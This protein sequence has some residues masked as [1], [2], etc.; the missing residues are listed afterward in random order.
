MKHY[1]N[2]NNNITVTVAS[3]FT[4]EE[5]YIGRVEQTEKGFIP[6]NTLD[7]A[8]SLPRPIAQAETIVVNNYLNPSI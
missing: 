6:Y 3:G 7:V 1:N 8:L 4:I 5:Q 2:K